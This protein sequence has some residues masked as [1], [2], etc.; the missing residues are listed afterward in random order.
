MTTECVCEIQ[1]FFDREWE[2]YVSVCSPF[3]TYLIMAY[4]IEARPVY[5]LLSN[6]T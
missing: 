4:I 3:N 1:K 6:Q 5:E 2:M